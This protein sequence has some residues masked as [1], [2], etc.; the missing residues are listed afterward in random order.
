MEQKKSQYGTTRFMECA[1][2]LVESEWDDFKNYVSEGNDPFC[3]IYSTAYIAL[4]GEG[5]FETLLGTME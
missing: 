5:D 4:H 1:Q 3:H 2:Y